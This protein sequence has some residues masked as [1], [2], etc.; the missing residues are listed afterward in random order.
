MTDQAL[1]SMIKQASDVAAGIPPS[2]AQVQA[3][4]PRPRPFVSIGTLATAASGIAAIIVLA[5]LPTVE[6]QPPEPEIDP[7]VYVLS[8]PLERSDWL[9]Q[10]I[11]NQVGMKSRSDWLLSGASP[12]RA[13]FASDYLVSDSAHLSNAYLLVDQSG[14]PLTDPDQP[15][16]IYVIERT[17][18]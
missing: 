9:L 4:H 2:M 14:K 5:N 11:S 16:V 12:N 3:D 6:V 10:S 13:A 18:P 1:R 17:T 8:D 7:D 15:N